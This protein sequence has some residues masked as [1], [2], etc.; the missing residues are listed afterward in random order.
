MHLVIK[1]LFQFG[2][3][4]VFIAGVAKMIFDCCYEVHFGANWLL[5]YD[6]TLICY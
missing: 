5:K 2:E 6:S 1:N 3:T 4:L